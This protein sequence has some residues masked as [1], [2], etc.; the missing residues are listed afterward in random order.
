[1]FRSHTN[2]IGR[3]ETGAAKIVSVG[4]NQ[5]FSTP[6]KNPPKNKA[7]IRSLEDTLMAELID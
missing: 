4:P 1:M 5:S 6:K 3:G 2:N 7:T